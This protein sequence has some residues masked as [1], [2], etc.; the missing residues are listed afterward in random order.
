[1]LKKEKNP[2]KVFISV[3][4]EGITG[5]IR[6]EETEQDKKDY[7][8]YRKLMT[9]EANAAIEG[10][11]EA[12]AETIIVRDGHD[13]ACNL[14]PEDLNENALL[15][16][17]WS[18]GPYAMMEGIDSSFDAAIFIGY[19]AKIGT[20]DAVLH[21]TMTS[22][23]FEVKL[24]DMTVPELGINAAIAGYFQ[25]PVVFVSGD[26]ALINQAKELIG[27]RE[28][29]IVKEGIGAAALNIHPKRA[30]K[31]I[32]EGVKKALNQRKNYEPYILK[33]PYSMEIK[34]VH[35]RE[36][37]KAEMIPGSKVIDERTVSFTSADFIEILKFFYLALH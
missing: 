31:L 15:V 21:H 8:L 35:E 34:F 16:R 19:H 32:K 33:P 7:S 24:N 3:D 10:A 28:F 6:W 4:M 30:Q 2:M 1:M 23:L 36:A 27:Q 14:I 11:V 18:G 26:R 29:V 25:V 17:G 9:A 13:S 12:G 20:R 37:R 22:R 5:V